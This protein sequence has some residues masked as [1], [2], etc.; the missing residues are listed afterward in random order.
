MGSEADDGGIPAVARDDEVRVRLVRGGPRAPR[1]R[2][3]QCPP[4]AWQ[5]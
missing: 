2:V 3:G 1:A 4:G 5:P